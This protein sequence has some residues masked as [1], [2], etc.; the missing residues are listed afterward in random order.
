M[1]RNFHSFF[2]NQINFQTDPNKSDT[3]DSMYIMHTSKNF[4]F[5]NQSSVL[6]YNIKIPIIS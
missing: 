2:T 3:Q 4:F 6:R 1:H 5:S